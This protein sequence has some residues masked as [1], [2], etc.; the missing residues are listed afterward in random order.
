MM[1]QESAEG[2]VVPPWDEGLNERSGEAPAV[3]QNLR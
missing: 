3:N 2:I 1:R